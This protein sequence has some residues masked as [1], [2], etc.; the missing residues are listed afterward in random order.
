ATGIPT[1]FN[2]LGLLLTQPALLFARKE[3]KGYGTIF[4]ALSKLPI[5]LAI[6]RIRDQNTNRILQTKVTDRLGRYVFF[7]NPGAFAV[8]VTKQ[9]YV[10][11]STY[12]SGKTEDV[13]YTDLFAASN[14]SLSENTRLAK[15]IP[16]DPLESQKTPSAITRTLILRRLQY[17]FALTGPIVSVVAFMITPTLLAGA[18][19]IIQIIFFVLFRRLAYKKPPKS[20]GIV[21]DEATGKPIK[22]AVIRIFETTY[23]KLLETQVTDARGRY[24]FLVGQSRYY[25]TAQAVGY[26]P[27][28]TEPIDFSSVAKGGLV[29]KD[30][31]LRQGS[32]LAFT[33]V[34]PPQQPPPVVPPSQ[35]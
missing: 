1:L 20:F 15:N 13:A 29:A 10:H 4:N 21:R 22:N 18:L 12:L 27:V 26:T 33:P 31:V 23:N 11:P 8:E 16:L 5:D 28:S 7:L 32:E 9:G 30:V 34:T 2:F 3:K 6:V 25:V 17:A 19:L 35:Q 14:L 24:A